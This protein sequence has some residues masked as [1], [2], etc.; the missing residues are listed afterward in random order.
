[1]MAV[2]QVQKWEAER[3]TLV[4]GTGWWEARGAPRVLTVCTLS[5]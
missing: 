5:T 1:M 2:R 4:G 3:C